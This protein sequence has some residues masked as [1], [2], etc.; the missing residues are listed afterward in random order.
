M[1]NVYEV[2]DELRERKHLSI[3]KLAILAQMPPTTLV[4]I[5]YRQ[6]VALS[7][8][9][10]SMIAKALGVEWT[11][12]VNEA[13]SQAGTYKISTALTDEEKE[14]ILEKVISSTKKQNSSAPKTQKNEYSLRDLLQP[15]LGLS[16]VEYNSL[17]SEPSQLKG[18]T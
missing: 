8:A 12:L 1:S 7:K 9:R 6:P 14:H 11:D 15:L 3:R 10:L 5:M 18:K 4:S 2:I 13:A 16:D 17:F